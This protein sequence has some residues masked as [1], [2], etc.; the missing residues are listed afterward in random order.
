M[1]RII[2]TLEIDTQCTVHDLRDASAW[3][4]ALSFADADFGE[5]LQA[6]AMR[7]KGVETAPKV[8][9]KKTAKARKP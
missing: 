2:V 8:T 7:A 5:V 4:S 1:A 3:R 6:T 9:P